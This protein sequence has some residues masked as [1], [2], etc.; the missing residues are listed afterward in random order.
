M[1]LCTVQ[2]M[3]V[4]FSCL[5]IIIKTRE[6]KGS[7]ANIFCEENNNYGCIFHLQ[8]FTTGVQIREMS[9]SLMGAHSRQ[10]RHFVW[11]QSVWLDGIM[12]GKKVPSTLAPFK[13]RQKIS[14]KGSTDLNAHVLLRSV[15]SISWPSMET[16]PTF[17]LTSTYANNLETWVHILNLCSFY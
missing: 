7:N 3:M 9:K 2:S 14:A 10:H 11:P 6:R 13:N 8:L 12:L 16:L 17:L 5:C 1:S 4:Y 15:T